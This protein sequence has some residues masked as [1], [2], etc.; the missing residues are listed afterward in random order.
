MVATIP[1]FISNF[2]LMYKTGLFNKLAIKNA[3]T[4][5]SNTE[6]AYF[7]NNISKPNIT[8]K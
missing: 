4:K 2:S 8:T 3:K 5:G 1:R 7:P 6:N